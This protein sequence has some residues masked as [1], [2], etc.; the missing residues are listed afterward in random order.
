MKRGPLLILVCSLVVSVNC[1]ALA[2]ANYVEGAGYMTCAE[3]GAKYKE[4]PGHFGDLFF[5][6][7]QGFLSGLASAGLRVDVT[8]KNIDEQESFLRDYC[9]EHPLERYMDAVI[10]LA[11][12]LKFVETREGM[13]R[14]SN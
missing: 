9:D 2:E 13:P 7:A 1:S 12:K 6:W 14:K 10:A 8:L 11:A 3:F 4:D 5:A